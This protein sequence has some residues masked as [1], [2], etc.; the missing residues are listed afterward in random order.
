MVEGVVINF[1]LQITKQRRKQL[2]DIAD[3][4]NPDG[5]VNRSRLHIKSVVA[6]P[7]LVPVPVNLPYT[8]DLFQ[9]KTSTFSTR[10]LILVHF[11]TVHYFSQPI[12]SLFSYLKHA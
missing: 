10:A 12:F 6:V 7:V 11:K 4:K 8:S 1:G 2:Y 9:P 3:Y 5:S